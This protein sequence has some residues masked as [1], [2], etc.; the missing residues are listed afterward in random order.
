[1]TPRT[2]IRTL[3]DAVPV[4]GGYRHRHDFEIVPIIPALATLIV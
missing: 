2:T 3:L 4:G 1:M